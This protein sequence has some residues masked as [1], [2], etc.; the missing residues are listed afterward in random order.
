MICGFA[1]G[2]VQNVPIF[3]NFTCCILLPLAAYYSLILDQKATKNYN[4]IPY[5]KGLL[6][7]LLTGVFAAIVGSFLDIILTLVFK[8][9]NFTMMIN[10]FVKTLEEFPLD[11]QLK[12]QMSDIFLNAKEEITTRG[13]SFFYTLSITIDQLVINSIFGS[14]GGLIGAKIINNNRERNINNQN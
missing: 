2:I 1:I 8:S 6:F 9:N 13:F 11:A 3:G 7:G 4:I 5:T 10:E 14:I 12:K